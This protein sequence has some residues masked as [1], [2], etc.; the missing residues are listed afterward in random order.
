MIENDVL[1]IV[2]KKDLLPGTNI[3]DSNWACK[4]KSNGKLEARLVAH[5]LSK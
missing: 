4:K 3:V 2:Q 1:E 5:A